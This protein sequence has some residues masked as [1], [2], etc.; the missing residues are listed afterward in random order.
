MLNQLI[1]HAEHTRNKSLHPVGGDGYGHINEDLIF[2]ER[3]DQSPHRQEPP[4]GYEY[5]GK[6]EVQ[7]VDKQSRSRSRGPTSFVEHQPV[8]QPQPLAPAP[9]IG[10]CPP[11][12]QQVIVSSGGAV[13][14]GGS[15]AH[16]SLGG[17][18]GFGGATGGVGF[19]GCKCFSCHPI[20]F[21]Y[22]H[23]LV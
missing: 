9:T 13:F 22:K 19:G 2:I 16:S 14:G 20:G 12:W 7:S 17:I 15:A 21:H 8:P 4:V 3:G 23:S 11:G 6:I 10:P 18:G 5:K 1:N